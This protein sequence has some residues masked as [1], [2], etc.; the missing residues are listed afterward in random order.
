[1]LLNHSSSVHR[2]VQPHHSPT[3][4]HPSV[5]A[6]VVLQPIVV[7]VAIVVATV[8]VMVYRHHPIHRLQN[9]LLD[10]IRRLIVPLP[11]RHHHVRPIPALTRLK[12]MMM[13]PTS[14]L[15][16][17]TTF[18]MVSSSSRSPTTSRAC[19][20]RNSYRLDPSYGRIAGMDRRRVDIANCMGRISPR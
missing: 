9:Y 6:A 10:V 1:M 12:S 3:W 4:I 7:A 13:P 17:T 15:V 20:A 5:V 2:Q 19:S 8:T 16:P 14:V 18:G 11:H